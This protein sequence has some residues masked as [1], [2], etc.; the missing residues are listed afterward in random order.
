MNLNLSELRNQPLVATGA[1]NRGMEVE[2]RLT[3][4]VD[5]ARLRRTNTMGQPLLYR[6][7]VC[8]SSGR[9]C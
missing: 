6:F 5:I 3:V 8:I 1:M 2:I 4:A 7:G 9:R